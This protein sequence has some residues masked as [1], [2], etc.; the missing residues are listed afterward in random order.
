[1]TT[2]HQ[3]RT[4][5]CRHSLLIAQGVPLKVVSEMLGHS[6]I[7]VTADIYAHVMAPAR[8]EAADA[9]DRAL[10]QSTS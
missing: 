6:S 5:T 4:P 8:D 10:G 7:T 3:L 9:M 2:D 1:V